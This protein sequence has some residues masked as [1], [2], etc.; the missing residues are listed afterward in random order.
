[1]NRRKF[2]EKSTLSSLGFLS[3][4]YIPNWNQE[5]KDLKSNGYYVGSRPNKNIF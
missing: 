5:E 4:A 3:A 2:I 1:M